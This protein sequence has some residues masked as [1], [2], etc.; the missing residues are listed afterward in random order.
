MTNISE[1]AVIDPAAQIGANVTIGP[2][3]V[4]GPDVVIGD[5]CH[6]MNNVCV[7][8]VTRIGRDNVLYQ[9]V[10]VGAAPQDLKYNGAPTETI[11]GNG[12]V[13]RENFTNFSL[14]LSV[15]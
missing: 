15:T 6:L 5:G 4:I 11:V 7:E 2:F 1:L 10:V 14:S 8:G 3:C 9:N 12:N 13:F